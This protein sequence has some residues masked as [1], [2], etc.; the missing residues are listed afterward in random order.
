MEDEEWKRL[1][2]QKEDEKFYGNMGQPQNV[3]EC[4][5]R[6]GEWPNGFDENGNKKT[7]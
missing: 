1:V 6:Y 5:N 2:Q 4:K 7:N 3:F